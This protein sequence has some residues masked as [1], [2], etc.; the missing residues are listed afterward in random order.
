MSKHRKPACSDCEYAD[1]YGLHDYDGSYVTINREVRKFNL[2]LCFDC[3]LKRQG[4][5]NLTVREDWYKRA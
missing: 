1:P 3:L 4:R 5:V 2:K